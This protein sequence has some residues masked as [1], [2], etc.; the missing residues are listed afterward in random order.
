MKKLLL[1][2][3]YELY[4]DG[5]GDVFKHII[6]PTNAI[7][8]V[9]D[10]Y[11]AKI[12]AFFEV[13]EYWRL[14]QE[15]E[16]GN[17]MGYD[18][19]PVEA[20]EKQVLDMISRGHDVQLHIHPQWVDAKWM[21]GKWIVDFNN[22]RLGT[23]SSPTMSLKQL[24]A[25]GKRTLEE[26]IRPS[27]PDYKCI[28][29]RAG[30]FNAQPSQEIVSIMRELGIKFDSSIVP[31][32]KEEGALSVYDYSGLPNDKG[33]WYVSDKLEFQATNETNVVELLHV[34]FPIVRLLKF[35]SWSRI[36]SIFQNRKSAQAS[37][38]A[39]TSGSGTGGGLMKKL[40]FFF[41]KEYQTWDYCLFPNW[42]HGYFLRKVMKQSQRDL[43][44]VIGHPKSLVSTQSLECMMKKTYS[45]FEY[46]TVSSLTN[47][48]FGGK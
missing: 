1:T 14:K 39:K 43:F 11:G 46:P 23:Y 13:V 41:K 22:W 20:M 3:D 25:D 12:T 27:F 37:F 10:H 2:L 33:F 36:K 34:T 42:M 40:S 19:N 47:N 26:I 21:D 6:E 17:R 38:A 48:F 31:G 15:W 7:L 44:V 32:A 16:S 24:I 4:G 18:S 9:G 28:A 29:L 45:K 8:E 35:M 5:S 30:C